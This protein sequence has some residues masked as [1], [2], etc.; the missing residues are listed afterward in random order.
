MHLSP[1]LRQNPN[2]ESSDSSLSDFKRTLC[3]L[4]ITRSDVRKVSQQWHQDMCKSYTGQVALISAQLKSHAR[5]GPDMGRP[6][7]PERMLIIIP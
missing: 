4:A 2:V 3:G 1:R 5:T 7:S 6:E